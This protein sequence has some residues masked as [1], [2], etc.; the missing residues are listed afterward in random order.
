MQPNCDNNFNGRCNDNLAYN[1]PLEFTDSLYKATT[2][3]TWEHFLLNFEVLKKKNVAAGCSVDDDVT[4]IK[5]Y[6]VQ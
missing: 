4:N 3:N 6:Q 1:D 5:V 2:H